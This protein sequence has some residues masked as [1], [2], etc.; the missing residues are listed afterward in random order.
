MPYSKLPQVTTDLDQA[1]ADLDEFGYCLLANA[2]D[3]G[4]REALLERLKR[5]A[6]AERNQQL[7]F[8][9][10]GPTQ[11]WGGFRD[12]SGRIRPE[13]FRAE[14]G[15]VNQRVWMLP[16]KGR[17]FLDLLTQPQVTELVRHMVGNEFLLSSYGANIAKPG[18]VKM[19]LHTD[20]WWMPE[21]TR[22]GRHGL[23]VGSM[24]RSRFD[25]DAANDHRTIAPAACSNVIWML[26]DFTESNGATRIVP[27]SHRSGRHPDP[28]RDKDIETV[29]AV[30]PAGTAIITDGRVWHGTGANIGNQLRYAVLTTFCGPQFRPQE[31]FAIGVA[32]EVLQEASPELLALFGFKVWNGYG[33][34]GDP[35]VEFVDRNEIPL[36]ELSA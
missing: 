14:N 25:Y 34:T 7:A 8:E 18:S 9:D 24:T 33:R 28:E 23:Q 16:N 30:A 29:A 19:N 13:A 11:Q 1:R 26:T 17:V 3:D 21:P 4:Y 5:Q 2:L 32:D 6:E 36:G 20:Q 35:T 12:A 22:P 31:N 10:G 15:G 27:G